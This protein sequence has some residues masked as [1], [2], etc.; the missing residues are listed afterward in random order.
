MKVK[1]EGFQPGN[2]GV[3]AVIIHK[4]KILLIKRH[5]LPIIRNPNIWSFVFG[6]REKG[7]AHIATVYREIREETSL[8]R[9]NLKLLS[10]PAVA[11]L[12]DIKKPDKWWENHIYIFKSN[13]DKITLDIENVGY[14]WAGMD[15]IKKQERYTNIFVDKD[16]IEKLIERALNEK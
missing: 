8:E 10:K 12:F 5:W 9:K 4:R 2:D 3:C 16:K 15:E 13:S 14:R 7:D 1:K 6:T 11:R